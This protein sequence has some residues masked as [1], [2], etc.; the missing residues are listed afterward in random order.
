[1]TSQQTKEIKRVKK[2]FLQ[3]TIGRFLLI[4]GA[5]TLAGVLYVANWM[6]YSEYPSD[7]VE[8]VRSFKAPEGWKESEFKVENRKNGCLV[9]QCPKVDLSYDID[10]KLTAEEFKKFVQSSY[11]G[12]D[13]S[14]VVCDL[15]DSEVM[16][17]R[18]NEVKEGIFYDIGLT[19]FNKERGEKVEI[20]ITETSLNKWPPE[21]GQ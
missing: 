8:K 20:T 5:L 2:P 7:L 10:R 12:I 16:T 18:V 21:E 13:T 17:C 11:I 9:V 3:R 6:S 14:K 4:L 1:M 19:Q 15:R